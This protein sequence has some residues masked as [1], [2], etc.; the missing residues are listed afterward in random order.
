[1]TVAGPMSAMGT[2][3][4]YD[5]PR[6]GKP[7]SSAEPAHLR[8]WSAVTSLAVIPWPPRS[9]HGCTPRI[10][11]L[12]RPR[13]LLTATIASVISLLTPGA[14]L[15]AGAAVP[16]A[17]KTTAPMISSD[18]MRAAYFPPQQKA[19]N[20]FPMN[21]RPWSRGALQAAAQIGMLLLAIGA[22]SARQVGVPRERRGWK[23]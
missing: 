16:A 2:A 13:A 8:A 5:L 18:V 11:Q 20:R 14:S 12:S 7:F 21:R 10:G 6:S 9:T 3:R 17:A 22:G 23:P 1:M 4:T 19:D 15:P